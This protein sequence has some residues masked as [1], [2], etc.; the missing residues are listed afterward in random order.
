MS[1]D[2]NTKVVWTLAFLALSVAL[3]LLAT[4]TAGAAPKGFKRCGSDYHRSAGWSDAVAKGIGCE[5][6][7]SQ[8]RRWWHGNGEQ[9]GYSCIIR[10]HGDDRGRVLCH[11]TRKDRLQQVRFSFTSY[12]G[13]G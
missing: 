6:A 8:A 5:G 7:R 11:R 2:R 4:A 12:R 3:L 9:Y 10:S 13:N 1:A